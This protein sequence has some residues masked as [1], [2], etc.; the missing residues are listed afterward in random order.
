MVL[1]EHEFMVFRGT[2]I[3]IGEFKVGSLWEDMGFMSTAVNPGSAWSGVKFDIT[4]PKGVRGM[5]IGKRSSH[6]HENEFLIDAGTK[7]R[8]LSVDVQR[9]VVKMVAIPKG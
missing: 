2:N 8:I 4:L 9:K 3:P 1:T 5:Y 7:F 6:S